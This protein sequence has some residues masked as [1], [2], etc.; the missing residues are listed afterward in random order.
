[1]SQE[2]VVEPDETSG[3]LYFDVHEHA[4]IVAVIDS[5]GIV[6]GCR[7]SIAL[8][9][10][11]GRLRGPLETHVPTPLPENPFPQSAFHVA[12]QRC[13]ALEAEARALK[14]PPHCPPPI[15]CARILGHLLRLAPAGNGQ[16]QLQREITS[17]TDNTVLMQVAG[18]YLSGFIRAFKR[19]S[20]PTPAPSEHPSRPSFED[21]HE[22]A[23]AMMEECQLDHRSAR[24]AAMN[25]DNNCCMITGWKDYK[26]GGSTVVQ[27]SHIIPEATNK[28]IGEE[29][30]KARDAR[31][32]QSG[33]AWAVL[34]MFTYI[35]IIKDL[36]GNRIHRL[37]NILSLN[38]YCHQLF[39]DLCLWLKPVGDVPHTYHVRVAK[40]EL[41]LHQR[42]PE[43]VNFSTTT[44]LPLPH[45]EYLALH[46]LCCEVAWM[47][48]A[49]EYLMDI[50]RRMDDTKVLA[51]DGSTADLLMKTLGLVEV[52]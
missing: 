26:H 7:D 21:A 24:A 22:Y 49:A 25:R 38:F 45:H 13:L 8:R 52:R 48:G 50:E 4:A 27:A 32:F 17:A 30:R 39:D 33:G 20:G 42:I 37:E 51:S 36:A 9:R 28:N 5:N 14:A 3:D 35:S 1:M 19:S 10:F 34:S 43:R 11:P 12:Y 46:A 18:V 41:K 31:V 16:G 6:S 40:E 23:T 29:R 2:V 15:V 47:S 44:T